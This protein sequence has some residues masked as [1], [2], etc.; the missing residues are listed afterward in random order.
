MKKIIA[1]LLSLAVVGA[2]VFCATNT[3]AV[4]DAAAAIR[5]AV[6]GTTVPNANVTYY[7]PRAGQAPEPALVS[8]I[9]GAKSTLDIAIYS[10]TDTSIENAIVNAENRGVT[11]R[12]ITDSECARNSS[13][14]NIL[15][16]LENDGIPVKINT[17][18][19]LMHM[20]VTIADKSIATTGSFNYTYSAETE[21]DEVFVVIKNAS[22]ATGFD[23]EFSTMWNDTNNYGN[24]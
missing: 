5:N 16:A 22:L 12:V 4:A 19:G 24:Y 20:K 2:G 17:H 21:N 7:F 10:I 13:Q 1:G 15:N 11:V 9:N 23:N 3:K 18:S 8:V 14:A 6:A